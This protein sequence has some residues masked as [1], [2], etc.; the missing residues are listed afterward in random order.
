VIVV[1]GAS[2]G[3]GRAICLGLAPEKPKLALAAR[4]VVRLESLK[5]ECEAHGAEALVAPTDVTSQDACK[6]LID[7]TVARFGRIDALVNNAG[8]TMWTTLEDVTDL[9]IFEQLMR[10]NYLSCVYC[11]YYALPHL[12]QSRGR[13]VAVSSVAGLAG[14]P[15][16]TG[17]SASKHAMFGFFNSLRIELAAAGVSVTMAAPDFVLS[18]MHRRA[19]NG[20]GGALGKSPM[21]EDQIMTAD[22]CARLIIEAMRRRKR[23]L[24]TS[25]RGKMGHWLAFLAPGLMDRIAAKAIAQRK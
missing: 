5:A 23:L 6:A 22:A 20:A 2:E 18:E 1:T 15:T 13:I 9:S 4:N 14:V 3:I 12:K 8:R 17:Y 21:Q 16:R 24:L 10:L 11:T 7:Q 19:F 25:R